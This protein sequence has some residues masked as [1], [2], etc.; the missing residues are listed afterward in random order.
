[1]TDWSVKFISCP[2]LYIN[3]RFIVLTEA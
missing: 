2:I 1:M 3:E